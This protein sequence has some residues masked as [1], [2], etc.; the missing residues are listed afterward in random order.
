MIQNASTIGTLKS[1][2]VF[3]VGQ[4]QALSSARVFYVIHIYLRKTQKRCGQVE[5]TLLVFG[6]VTGRLLDFQLQFYLCLLFKCKLE[7]LL[8]KYSDL[9]IT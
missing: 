1:I 3:A 9:S 6:E 7:I 5:Y 2:L 8:E 4:W